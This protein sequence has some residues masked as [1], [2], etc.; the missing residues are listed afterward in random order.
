MTRRWS[1]RTRFVAAFSLSLLPLLGVV[2][3]VIDQALDNSQQQIFDTEVAFAEVVSR[4]LTQTLQENHEV[5][6][7]LATTNRIRS[8]ETTQAQEILAQAK[9]LRPSLTGLFLLDPQQ[10]VVAVSGGV[11]P[12]AF[13]PQIKP[14]ADAALTAGDSAITNKLT[15][16]EGDI[17]MIAMVAP[18]LAEAETER[19]STDDA[20]TPIG[21]IGSF[22]SVERLQRSFLAVTG[23]AGSQ[24]TIAL[25]GNNGLIT[26]QGTSNGGSG[27]LVR[28]L[29]APLAEAIAGKR[30]RFSY[31]DASGD[32]RLA[33]LQPVEYPGAQWAVVVS[34]PSPTTYGPNQ[35][36]L[37]NGLIALVLAVAATLLLAVI[38]GEVTARPLR[39]LTTQAELI[40]EGALDQPLEPVGR[41]EVGA[42]SLSLR[43]MANRLTNQ[44]RDTEESREEV[45]RQN[46]LMRE[47]L[48]RTVR[49]QED[50]RRRIAS[51]IHDAVSPLITGAL[52]QVRALKMLEGRSGSNNGAH[53]DE[54]D[55]GLSEAADLLEQ[56]MDELHNVIFDLRPPDLDDVGVVAAVD[57]YVQQINRT[58]L[59]CQLEVTGE[60]RRLSPEVRLGV[61]RIIQEALHNALRHAHADEAVV[62]LEFLDD[63][64]RVSIRDNGSGFDPESAMRSASLGLLSMRERAT[65][66]GADLEIVSRPGAGTIVVLERPWEIDLVGHPEEDE[67]APYEPGEGLDGAQDSAE[68][69]EVQNV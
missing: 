51:E 21:A 4:G 45:E 10:N 16:P 12:A 27:D 57:R 1:L 46:D 39:Q 32:E 61:Y 41:G 7:S 24:T 2:L 52:Y 23:E 25:V 56:S 69:I 18:V 9:E 47:L 14:V 66:I 13:L 22:I 64:L 44:V 67:D 59:P 30:V 20:G 3:Y 31:K 15:A 11:D 50:E 34:G 6:S 5:L 26:N 55:V 33:V 62:K 28:D 29:E 63:L 49:L 19:E 36:L 54:H 60:Q 40:A 38:F 68:V 42:L 17:E 65:A 37:R 58:G 35:D 8:M 48:R 53:D 43:D